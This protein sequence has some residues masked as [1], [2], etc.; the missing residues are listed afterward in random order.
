MGCPTAS[1]AEAV[2][3]ISRVRCYNRMNTCRAVQ[4][5]PYSKIGVPLA[6]RGYFV[7]NESVVNY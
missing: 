1:S 5:E 3:P 4:L 2:I 6:Q 7:V